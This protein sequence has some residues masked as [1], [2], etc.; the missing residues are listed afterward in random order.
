MNQ[1]T[2]LLL[3]NQYNKEQE[4]KKYNTLHKLE[5]YNNFNADIS[6]KS[7]NEKDELALYIHDNFDTMDEI[8]MRHMALKC[9]DM[10]KIKKI[11]LSYELNNYKNKP[12]TNMSLDA[13]LKQ[14]IRVI[15]RYQHKAGGFLLEDK[16][17]KV[18]RHGCKEYDVENNEILF[19][20]SLDRSDVDDENTDLFIRKIVKQLNMIS[21]NI[22]VE[23]RQIF[24]HK[25]KIAKILLWA[26]DKNIKV[27]KTFVGL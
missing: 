9:L 12:I 14:A 2:L 19:V 6:N 13:F 20:N 21:K 8:E 7:K 18:Y 1:N 10:N 5:Y 25:D 17:W 3:L 4:M 16:E 24:K 15:T 27:E 23:I 26:T 22:T 11:L